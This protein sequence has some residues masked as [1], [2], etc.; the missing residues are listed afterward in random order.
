VIGI[1]NTSWG[2]IQSA[3]VAVGIFF[4]LVLMPVIDK[5]PRITALFSG[6]M[7]MSVGYFMVGLWENVVALVTAAII[8]GVGGEVVMAVR[9]ALVGD[10][11]NPEN[12]GRVMGTTLAVEYIGSVIGGVVVAYLYSISHS[13]AFVF[14]GSILLMS[15][16]PLVKKLLSQKN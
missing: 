11:I 5:A 15:T 1:D 9:R 8:A 6:L 10:Y 12:R 14:S 13:Y 3:A 2:V 7:L 4:G 16:A